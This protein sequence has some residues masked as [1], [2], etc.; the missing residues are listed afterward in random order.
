MKTVQMPDATTV[1]DEIVADV[2]KRFGIAKAAL[3]LN[4]TMT[5][6]SDYLKLKDELFS[7]NNPADINAAIREHQSNRT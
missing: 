6:K 7:G 3:F 5:G 2:I 1:R 4:R